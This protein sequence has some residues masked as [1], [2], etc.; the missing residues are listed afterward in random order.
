MLNKSIE[1]ITKV[2]SLIIIL[3]T[4]VV[5]CV[6]FKASTSTVGICMLYTVFYIVLPGMYIA[7]IT[8]LNEK[9][10]SS[11]LARGFFIGWIFILVCY[12]SSVAI[13]NNILL[14]VLGPVLSMA[15]IVKKL[16]EKRKIK[17][18][19][20]SLPGT[21]YVFVLLIFL[22]A[23]FTTQFDYISPAF[24]EYSFMKPDRAYHLG[25]INS[26]SRGYPVLNPWIN[27]RVMSY[28]VFTEILYAVPV[29]L[30]GLSADSVVMSFSPYLITFVFSISLYSF[31]KEMTNKENLIGVYCLATIAAN[32]FMIKAFGVSYVGFH[33]FS[34]INS[35]GLG[36]CVLFVLIPLFK[37]LNFGIRENLREII[38]ITALIMLVTGIKGP[39][40][41]TTI[42]G[43]WGTVVLGILLK[44][45]KVRSVVPIVLFSISFV[46]IY[47]AFM[48]GTG[49]GSGGSLFSVGK[50]AEILFCRET[51]ITALKSMGAP[52]LIRKLILLMII[53][54][55]MYMAFLVP[56][57]V[58]TIREVYTVLRGKKE[59]LIERVSVYAIA[60]VGYLA[61]MLLDYS[62][63]SQV[64][65][66]F[67]SA[68]LAPIIS[69]WL[70]EDLEH[71]KNVW[72]SV[73]MT[74]FVVMMLVSSYLFF[75]YIKSEIYE[76]IYTYEN[77]DS[78]IH[79]KYRDITNDEYRG[80]MWLKNNTPL[81]SLIVSDR[82]NSVP[83]YM[84]DYA[85]KHHNTYFMYAAYSNR[86]QY[87]EGS[88]FSF[89]E[90]ENGIRKKMVEI[91][92]SLYDIKNIH[93]SETAKK[94]G[95]DYLVV[96]KRFN[97][98]GNLE[99]NGCKLRYS[100][101]QMDI[102]EF[103]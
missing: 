45:I 71:S 2:L 94:I 73:M 18:K 23:M 30:F 24:A 15:Y 57:V 46:V 98:P 42:A 31:Y 4:T 36:L 1:L 7:E 41:I 35:F 58:G 37:S 87:I 11:N 92:N 66:G 84:Y 100:N 60:I 34:N 62:G 39:I 12:F 44:K 75:G 80:L 16:K 99:S 33:I 55:C 6:Y 8:K 3:A 22:Q 90:S 70:F 59:Y 52:V 26:L 88:G 5:A 97:N 38:F 81:D 65:F 69:I 64:Y 82:Y 48:R 85:V 56:F 28:H 67:V 79:S 63:H 21:I 14:F 54:I 101:G 78:E 83:I 91:N 50:V 95:A 96:S 51:I 103:K 29:R 86:F 19:R 20:I 61:L 49:G 93:R 72:K 76:T 68:Y 9:N 27:G 102:Y 13:N 77:K 40:G 47:L 53:T 17:E 32:M 10:I 74:V 25:I 43:L 89:A